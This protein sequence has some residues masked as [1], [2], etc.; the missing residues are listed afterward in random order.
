MKFRHFLVVFLFM[1]FF[2]SILTSISY[3]EVRNIPDTD[4]LHASWSPDG[5]KILFVSYGVMSEGMFLIK[6]DG[7]EI[8]EIRGGIEPSWTP[9]GNIIM[10]NI[11]N[12]SEDIV[13][14]DIKTQ[15]IT[16]LT[17]NEKLFKESEPKYS[18][19][20]GEIVFEVSDSTCVNIHVINLSRAGLEKI[21]TCAADSEW[22][23]DGKKI[24]YFGYEIQDSI[25]VMNSDGTDKKMLYLIKP[26]SHISRNFRW[27]PDSKYLLL[28]NGSNTITKV[29]IDDPT[30]IEYIYDPVAHWDPEYSPDGNYVTFVSSMDGGNPDLFVARS[31]GSDL[32]RLVYDTN[33]HTPF[34]PGYFYKIS[35][36]A[37][38]PWP[39]P[40]PTEVTS[41]AGPA[42]T[43]EAGRTPSIPGF[44]ALAIF[45]VLVSLA[46]ITR[47]K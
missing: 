33:P 21:A 42:N 35:R 28:N 1:I 20:G 37:P 7:S 38:P 44:T 11:F 3:A 13:L 31:N 14:M 29:N 5:Q 6:P 10:I 46:L 15:N 32:H 18:P 9:D 34:D 19:D 25:W 22:S 40:E 12:G 26:F 45:M 43:S 16:R 23:P 17:F 4:E 30:N 27:T 36:P 24:I 8:Q 39:M 47:I 41:I 2:M